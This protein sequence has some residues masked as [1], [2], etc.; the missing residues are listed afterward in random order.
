MSLWRGAPRVAP[1]S[2]PLLRYP[3]TMKATALALQALAV[4]AAGALSPMQA[5][6]QAPAKIVWGCN[7]APTEPLDLLARP[8]VQGE[9]RLTADQST[10]LLAVR[11]HRHDAH[12]LPYEGRDLDID[13]RVLRQRN[14][15]AD[16][17][18]RVANAQAVGLL[19]P[20]QRRRLR[21]IGYQTLGFHALRLAEVR[22]SLGLRPAQCNAL[23]RL[24]MRHI[25]LRDALGTAWEP[26]TPVAVLERRLRELDAAMDAKA[27]TILTPNQREA[28]RALLGRP[29]PSLAGTAEC[30]NRAFME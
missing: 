10:R 6:A 23:E 11:T 13:P 5:T 1:I 30:L 7:V 22:W 27:R 4:L 15:I 12:P 29:V 28:Y 14:R 17:N 25:E 24:G 2:C 8:A 20:V 9:L 19:T 18:L 26:T 16:E 21:A 3:Q